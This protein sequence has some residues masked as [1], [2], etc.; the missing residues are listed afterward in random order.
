MFAINMNVEVLYMKNRYHP[1]QG[2]VITVHPIAEV[3]EIAFIKQMNSQ[4]PRDYAIFTVGINVCLRA[5]DLLGL[6]VGQVRKLRVE[7][8]LLVREGK[9]QKDRAITI[10]RAVFEAILHG[11]NNWS[12]MKAIGFSEHSKSSEDLD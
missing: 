7:D 1:K 5:G 10:N 6:T 8:V 4:R 12:T 2:S 3:D 11:F 9:T